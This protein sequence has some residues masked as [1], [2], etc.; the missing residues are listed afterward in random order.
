MDKEQRQEAVFGL[1]DGT[2]SVTGFIFALLIH[3]SPDSA[4]AIGGLGGAVSAGISMSVGEVEKGEEPWRKRLGV[5]TTMLVASLAGSLIPVVPFWLFSRSVAL[6]VGATGCLCVAGII[7]FVKS[8]GLAGYVTAYVTLLL[9]AALT[10]GV[11]SLIPAS[12]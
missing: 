11:V 1:F 12:A 9:A 8:K 6:I 2:V 3:H 4:I 10:L 7:G 5:G